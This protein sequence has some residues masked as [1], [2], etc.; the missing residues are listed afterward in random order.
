MKCGFLFFW[1]MELYEDTLVDAPRQV[2]L[3]GFFHEGYS[4]A[5]E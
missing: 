4:P 3:E 5:I 2:E 1:E